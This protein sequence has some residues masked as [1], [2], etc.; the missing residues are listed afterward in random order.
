MPPLRG[1]GAGRGLRHIL[2]ASLKHG[3]SSP[4]QPSRTP[5]PGGPGGP[6]PDRPP[7]RDITGLSDLPQAV[8]GAFPPNL[9]FQIG[10]SSGRLRSTVAVDQHICACLRGKPFDHG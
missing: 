3:L 10:I 6:A 5:R 8:E 1:A 7:V 2:G 9:P 4:R